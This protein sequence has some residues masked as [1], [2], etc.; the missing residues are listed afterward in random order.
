MTQCDT[1]DNMF[2][3]RADVWQKYFMLKDTFTS[4]AL[5]LSLSV[6]FVETFI[7]AKI[8]KYSN[9]LGNTERKLELFFFLPPTSPSVSK[10]SGVVHTC[11]E[12]TI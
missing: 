7:P 2:D 11:N 9:M 1:L 12:A 10:S 8:G 5:K 6:Q 4:R 3:R